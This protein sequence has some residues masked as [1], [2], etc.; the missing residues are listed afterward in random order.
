MGCFF[1][2]TIESKVL[3]VW[4]K[5]NIPDQKKTERNSSYKI[6]PLLMECELVTIQH[7][8]LHPFFFSSKTKPFFLPF[9]FLRRVFSFLSTHRLLTIIMSRG[10]R[11]SQVDLMR[12]L[13]TG[14]L[15]LVN[16]DQLLSSDPRRS[17]SQPT[18]LPVAPSFWSSCKFSFHLPTP[19][20][21][22]ICNNEKT[23]LVCF[24]CSDHGPFCFDCVVRWFSENNTCPICRACFPFLDTP[25]AAL[26]HPCHH[27]IDVESSSEYETVVRMVFDE[28]VAEHHCPECAK[29]DNHPERKNQPVFVELITS[30]VEKSRAHRFLHNGAPCCSAEEEDGPLNPEELAV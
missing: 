6:E 8:T 16:L 1:L 26:V 27:V 13:M 11:L 5:S 28:S 21:C 20:E 7:I 4:E 12:L 15:Q 2:Y 30:H 29:C 23:S 22:C 19:V 17:S 24:P 14:Q 9:P 18:G 10:L 3:E 25:L